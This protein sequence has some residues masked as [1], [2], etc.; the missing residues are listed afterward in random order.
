MRAIK[1][2]IRRV[3]V[4]DVVHALKMAGVTDMTILDVME[5]GKEADPGDRRVS[6][7]LGEEYDKV[8]KIEIVCKKEKA[9]GL[10]KTL[11]EAAYTGRPGDGI[12]YVL[13][14]EMAVKIR[15]GDAET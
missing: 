5:V 2:Y 12:I 3:K 15:T 6:A 7:E 10:V 8:A 1:A 14:V 11:R 4:D 13:P 9:A